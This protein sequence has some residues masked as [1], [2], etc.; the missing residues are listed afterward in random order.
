MSA[1]I[2]TAEVDGIISDTNADTKPIKE[3]INYD[4]L[5]YLNQV[6]EIIEHGKVRKDRTGTGTLSIFGMQSRY[7]LRNS[8]FI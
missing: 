4:E 1:I 7:D 8:S 2:S 5:K 3:S 6:K